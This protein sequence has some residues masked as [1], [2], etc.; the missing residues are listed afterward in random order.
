M[1]V[2]WTRE[3]QQVIDLRDRSLLVSA[4]AGSGKTAVLVERIVKR[5][6][7][8]SHP[9]DVDRLLVVTFTNAAAAQLRERV[10][11]AIEKRLEQDP[12]NRHLKR[13][14]TLIHQAKITTIDSFCLSVLRE[15]FHRIDLDPSFRIGDEGELRLLR[16]D[17]L[18]ELI[19]EKYQEADPEF[20]NFWDAYNPGKDDGKAPGLIL[21]L[22]EFAMANPRPHTWLK[23][24][25]RAYE[26]TSFE[27]LEQ[28]AWMRGICS[29]AI[30]TVQELL[31]LLKRTLAACE[32]EGDMDEYVTVIREEVQQLEAAAG[33]TGYE[34]LR[35]GLSSLRYGKK[36]RRKKSDTY[37]EEKANRLWE[38]RKQVKDGLEKLLEQQLEQDPE[39][40]LS[41][42]LLAGRHAGILIRLTDQFIDRYSDAKRKRNLV[43]FHDLEHLALAVLS[44]ETENGERPT[45]AA[46]EYAA[47][48]EEIMIDEY[49]D[50]NYV[51]EL[52]LTSI[53]RE[54]TGHPN[55]FMVGDVKQSIYRFRLA[56][57][58]L[59]M[60]K[61]QTFTSCDSDHQKI[62]LHQNFRS[63]ETVLEGVNYFF[64]QI[65]HMSLGNVEY[66]DAAALHPGMKF[67]ETERDVG[68]PV[69]LLL[70]DT[71]SAPEAEE[72]QNGN[73]AEEEAGKDD[74][75]GS[76]VRYNTREWEAVLIAEEIRKLTDKDNGKQV[77]DPE[78][79]CY[80]TA[81]YRDITIL[82]RTISGWAEDFLPVL[83]SRGIPSVAESGTGYFSAL[84]VQT[85]LNLLQ[86]INNPIQ[87][88]P[89]AGVLHSAI[90]GFSSEEL[91]RIRLGAQ[92]ASEDGL[93]GVLLAYRAAHPQEELG[94]RIS[95]FLIRLEDYR[96]K[97]GYLPLHELV[98]YVMEESG[99]Y[100]YVCAMPGG[101]RRKANLDMLL[102]KA[103]RFEATSYQGVFQ[104]VRYLEK[105]KTY[106]V[107]YPE[108]TEG[109]S[110]NAVRIMSIH[111]SKGLEF[112]IVIVAGLGKSFNQ[113]DSRQSV[114]L[115]PDYGIGADA[116]NIE[117]RTIAPTAMKRA[118]AREITLDNLG[119]ELR[120]LYVAM[121]RAKEV[122]IMTGAKKSL[123]DWLQKRLSMLRTD[124][125]ELSWLEL[126]SAGSYLDWIVPVMA[127]NDCFDAVYRRIGLS[128]P[129]SGPCYRSS[130]RLE[131]D[132][133]T[134]GEL[135]TAETARRL[136]AAW[137]REQIRDAGTQ[138]LDGEEELSRRIRQRASY[139]YC[140]DD[141]Y[142][143]PASLSV[144]EIKKRAIE[145][146]EEEP[147]YLMKEDGALE[148]VPQ[149]GL[150]GGKTDEIL[151]RFLRGEESLPANERG[152]LYH[153]LF[154][155]L[156]PC[157]EKSLQEQF[158][159]L[160]EKQ[161]IT[162][163]EAKTVR[164][165]DLE[166]FYRSDL[167]LRALRARKNGTFHSESPFCLG[168]AA[169]QMNPQARIGR[170]GYVKIQGIIDAWF[171]EDGKWIL[172]DYKTDRMTGENWEEKLAVRYRVQ[173]QY[174]QMALEKMS[175]RTVDE[176][177]LYSVSKGKA[178]RL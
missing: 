35:N 159:A 165:G 32:E 174:Y 178:V 163:R 15:Q 31:E 28:T 72:D 85:V 88:I 24:C 125:R 8:G 167:G 99:Y 30:R 25:M 177:Y 74:S 82:L 49:Q 172:Y 9:I 114:I 43:D 101:A 118:L 98:A 141:M 148:Y 19:E 168:V 111:K 162:E 139:D 95:R 122:L 38:Q 51:Q 150:E 116:I 3:Q 153:Y 158:Q 109:G 100:N 91:A 130:A 7:E 13:Q 75:S 129:F 65:M 47:R 157:S 44:E 50:S 87:D 42:H 57:P 145:E 151:P 161:I 128:A 176:V 149:D 18:Q 69:R 127:K 105:L 160:V 46:E 61:Y 143:L 79:G 173:L 121:T 156:D 64:Y 59:F 6:S 14:Q 147:L 66:D 1:A 104:F 92:D 26:V 140:Y 102:E 22:Y 124:C 135:E 37:D 56:R 146:Q 115:H 144:S 86:I 67:E 29:R 27:E 45:A 70:L 113:Q 4:A 97:S 83:A 78:Q 40:L 5:I 80:R 21:Q 36:P 133:L 108:A 11:K 110:S 53:S 106:S 23:Q 20:L 89:L 71:E 103:E 134:I 131:V 10:Q 41:L 166:R 164:I 48:F 120:V 152:T 171:E 34:S 132:L 142:R 2:A 154:E 93:Y 175:G 63:R 52:I 138:V 169:S 39:T 107:D 84:E 136:D 96:I 119:E 90:G 17:V 123:Y 33:L 81:Q 94:R 12:S 55:C 170:D 76:P 126:S 77:W 73:G 137:Y 155:H 16:E 62:E 54:R 112:P 60:E 58:E 68:G 117:E